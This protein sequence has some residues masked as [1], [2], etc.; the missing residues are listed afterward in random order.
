MNN[1]LL[2][3]FKKHRDTLFQQT[4]TKLQ[5]TLEYI[6]NKQME[7]FSFTAP[8]NLVVANKWLLGVSS[9]ECTNSDFTITDE[10]NSFSITPPGHWTS[11]S[12][13]KTIDELNKLTDLRSENDIDL[14]VEQIWKRGILLVND[15]SLSS[16]GIFKNELLAE[17]KNVKYIGFEDMVYKYQRT[18]KEILNL[19]DLK[20]IPTSTTIYSTNS[21]V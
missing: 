1:E 8:N 7:N 19:S 17:F 15:Y 4:K 3:L 10:N 11:K 5:E 16:F 9:L 21:D 6:L 18:Y 2:L 20:Y 14:H 13:E 12:A